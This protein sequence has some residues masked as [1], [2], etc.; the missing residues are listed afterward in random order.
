MEFKGKLIEKKNNTRNK[1]KRNAL[2]KVSWM[3][4]FVQ[5]KI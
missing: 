3:I 5:N 4:A 1:V 2:V